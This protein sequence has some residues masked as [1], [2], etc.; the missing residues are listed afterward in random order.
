MLQDA[1]VELAPSVT[2]LINKPIIDGTVPDVWNIAR[3]SPL[4]KSEDK[5][6]VQNYRPIAV[7][8]IL[9]KVMERAVYAQ[10]SAHLDLLG[11][12]YQHQYG[13]RHGH[14]TAQAIV[15]AAVTTKNTAHVK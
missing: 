1:E 10:L 12:L 13:F 2:F 11:F 14:S 7:L 4:C 8:P 9:S 6:L 3:V 5:I 15:W